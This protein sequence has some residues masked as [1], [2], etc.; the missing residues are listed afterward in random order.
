[1][2][3]PKTCKYDSVRSRIEDGDGLF[4][5]A[6]WTPGNKLIEWKTGS[7]W[8]HV[9]Q[10]AW[11]GPKDQGG[12]LYLLDT[13][14]WVGA[15]AVLFRTQVQQHPGHWAWFP[16]CPQFEGVYDRDKAKAFLKGVTGRPYGWGALLWCGLRYGLLTRPFFRPDTDDTKLSQRLQ[17][18][19]MLVS[20]AD[21]KAG[22][23]PVPGMGDAFTTP[24]D[25]AERSR[26][27]RFECTLV[28]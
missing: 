18:C 6:R 23:D 5:R 17:F 25:L 1:V 2:S 12:R 15:R 14:Q 8:I 28:P 22:V 13:V 9:G 19:S 21:R 4:F 27:R 26:L 16:I 20:L 7:R 10:A 3:K 24:A 11:W